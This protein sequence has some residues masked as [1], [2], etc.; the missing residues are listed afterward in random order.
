M[1]RK[2]NRIESPRKKHAS[3]EPLERRRL[4]SVGLNNTING[5]DLPILTPIVTSGTKTP[6][7]INGSMGSDH[8]RLDSKNGI[9]SLVREKRDR[10]QPCRRRHFFDSGGPAWRK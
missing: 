7:V 9:I 10:K 8:I 5:E 1:N 3:F 4:M 6:L 2:R